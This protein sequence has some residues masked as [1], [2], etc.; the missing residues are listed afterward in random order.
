[1]NLKLILIGGL[2][3]VLSV[4][5]GLI[6]HKEW[7]KQTGELVYLE[8]APVDPRSLMQ[9]DYMALSFALQRQLA[10]QRQAQ[11]GDGSDGQ[12]IHQARLSE[13]SFGWA[14]IIL[15]AR[16][17]ARLSTPSDAARSADKD[18]AD[19]NSADQGLTLRYRVRNG[20]IWLGTNAFFFEEG[21]AENYSNARFGEFRV[22]RSTGEAILVA[23]R[24][25]ALEAL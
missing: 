22:N 7:I 19:Q 5:N 20:Q 25:Q 24:N 9:G 6:A 8:L 16:N 10:T 23:L 2:T 14:P 17:V 4:V 11:I 21:K 13:G 15:D 18:S 12:V 3:L 1:M